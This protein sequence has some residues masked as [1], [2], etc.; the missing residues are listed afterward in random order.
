MNY[1]QLND[2]TKFEKEEAALARHFGEGNYTPF[3][4]KQIIQGKLKITKNDFIAGEIQ[5]IFAAMKQLGIG[6]SYN[7]YPESLQKYL[8]RKIWTSTM[9]D[10]RNEIFE[11]GYLENPTF[12]KPKDRLKRFTGFVCDTVDDLYRCNNASNNVKIWCSEPVRFLSEYRCPIINGELRG[13]FTDNMMKSH[14]GPYPN[15]KNY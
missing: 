15:K 14:S 8:H 10:I 13:L 12:I 3:Y 9:R 7:D 6:Y 4:K 2:N 5:V 1:L 11:N